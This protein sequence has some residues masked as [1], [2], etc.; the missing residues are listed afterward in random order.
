MGLRSVIVKKNSKNFL[1]A[2]GFPLNALDRSLN[3]HERASCL[4]GKRVYAIG[5]QNLVILQ[6]EHQNFIRIYEKSE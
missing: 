6:N 1:T 2:I 4:F 3:A 5:L